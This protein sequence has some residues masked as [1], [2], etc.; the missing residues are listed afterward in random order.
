MHDY[1]MRFF[2]LLG[3]AILTVCSMVE[4][5]VKDHTYQ[6]WDKYTGT[7]AQLFYPTWAIVLGF[8]LA[9]V[10]FLP[11]L[12]GMFKCLKKSS[13]S[14]MPK[15]LYP[16]LPGMSSIHESVQDPQAGPSKI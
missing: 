5:V 14:P 16:E 12:V 1:L 7:K 2:T 13:V 15:S 10:T 8:S 6:S 9:F 11:I 3:I 4:L